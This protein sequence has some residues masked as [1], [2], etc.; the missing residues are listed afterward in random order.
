M[1]CVAAYLSCHEN[2]IMHPRSP[3]VCAYADVSPLYRIPARSLGTTDLN[4]ENE[5]NIPK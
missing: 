3:F 1:Y 5:G 4:D 2:V